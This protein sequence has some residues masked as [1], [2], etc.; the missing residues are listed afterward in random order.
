MNSDD[1]ILT[2]IIAAFAGAV[3][4]AMVGA[5]VW[6]KYA[7]WTG[8]TAG[9]VSVTVGFLTAL[10]A[11][12]ASRSRRALIALMCSIIAVFGMLLGKYLDAKW[13]PPSTV[14]IMEAQPDMPPEYAKR[15]A[16]MVEESEAGDST[17]KLIWMRTEWYDIFYYVIASLVAFQMAYSTKLYRFIFRSG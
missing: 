13:N 2:E 11:M 17:W 14:D 4:G 16:K 6:A 9:W 5:I 3:T 8:M 10:G 12:V 7:G 15:I 1:R